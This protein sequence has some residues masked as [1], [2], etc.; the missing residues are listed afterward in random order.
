MS[1]TGGVSN[2]FQLTQFGSVNAGFFY[3]RVGAIPNDV[4]GGRR[5]S[6][7]PGIELLVQWTWIPSGNTGI[8]GNIGASVAAANAIVRRQK[9]E[10]NVAC[11]GNAAC[12]GVLQILSGVAAVKL[13]NT[14]AA[15]SAI[16]NYGKANYSI[17]AGKKKTVKIELNKKGQKALKS[18]KLQAYVQ[19][20]PKNGVAQTINMLFVKK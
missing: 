4:G 15:R 2:A 7:I 6:G 1:T 19:I 18:G 9:A 8:N 16:T 5:E 20:K 10:I 12:N 13:R 14:T 11:N 17:K 3:P